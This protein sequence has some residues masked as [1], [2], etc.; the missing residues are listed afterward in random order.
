MLEYLF[1]VA[2]SQAHAASPRAVPG[3]AQ[4]WSFSTTA[5]PTPP[6]CPRPERAAREPRPEP[7]ARSWPTWEVDGAGGAPGAGVPAE[8]AHNAAAAA[9]LVGG[10]LSGNPADIRRVREAVAT[11][12]PRVGFWGDSHAARGPLVARFREVLAG[13]AG[14]GGVGFVAAPRPGQK[15]SVPGVTVCATGTWDRRWA[16]AAAAPGGEAFGPTGNV[17]EA[18]TAADGGWLHVVNATRLSLAFER[19]PTTGSLAVSVDGS[20]PVRVLTAGE[21]PGVA[22]FSL[23]PGPHLLTYQLLGD[24]PVRLVGTF[25]ETGDAGV[26][27]DNLA[28]SGSV[29]S[30][31]RKWAPT[32]LRSWLDWLDYDLIVLEYGTNEASNP[33]LT[34]ESYRDEVRWTLAGV[35]AVLPSVACL[36]VGPP[37]RAV[38]RDKDRFA[39]FQAIGWIGEAQATVGREFGCAWWGMQPAMGGPGA[40]VAWGNSDPPRMA[41]DYTHFAEV[42]ARAVG[43]ALATAV[44]AS[45]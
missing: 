40:V 31:W 16:W 10:E 13:R 2:V 18:S 43:E 12:T 3:W 22:G 11:A 24:A 29:A 20:V 21:G 25:V 26:V 41:R 15:V 38:R 45:P 7:A 8:V 14:D 33:A 37:D 35:R 39:V 27:V 44:A 9:T 5:A 34:L 23:P 28:V 6:Q 30:T 32:P 17:A 36:L 42:G 4:A 19:G 1:V